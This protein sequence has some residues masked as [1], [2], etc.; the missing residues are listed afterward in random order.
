MNNTKNEKP[1]VYQ[2]ARKISDYRLH[3]PCQTYQQPAHFVLY[4][5]ESEVIP[6]YNGEIGNAVPFSVFHGYEIRFEFNPN[7]KMRTVNR[8]GRE[9]LPYFQ[10]V[11]D[12]MVEYWDGNNY[13]IR[14]TDDALQAMHDIEGAILNAEYCELD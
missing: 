7:L 12:G 3:Y 1:L 4:Y 5:D 14:L 8:L 2:P 10:R 9:L 13:R 11:Q 6:T